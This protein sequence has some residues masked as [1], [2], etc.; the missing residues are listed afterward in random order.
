MRDTGNPPP[1]PDGTPPRA[2]SPGR[3]GTGRRARH[4]APAGRRGAAPRRVA[5]RRRW[6]DRVLV[7]DPGLIQLQAGWRSLVAMVTSLAAG[8]VASLALG[9]PVLLG[10]MVGGMMGLMSAFAVAEN[11]WERVARAV[12]WMP[13][14]FGAML[15]LAARFD[16]RTVQIVL[17]VCAMTLIFLLS[18]YGPLALLT[19]MML[20]NGVM[21]GMLAGIPAA[22]TGRAF[23]VALLA[24]AAVLATRL[25]LCFP[26]PREDLLRTQRAFVVE[27]R[28]LAGTAAAALGPDAGRRGVERRL[29]RSLR[30]LNL[31]TVTIDGRLAQP[32]TSADP[33]TAELL[34]R[35]LFDA[36]LALRG[37][38][39]SAL[40]LSRLDP[41]EPLREAVTAALEQVR[42]APLTRAG[43]LRRRVRA[44]R[45][46]VEE[47]C[48]E[49]R[50][51][52]A[53]GPAGTRAVAL[54]ARTADLLDVL[55]GSLSSWLALGRDLPAAPDAVPFQQAVALENNR[56]TGSAGPVRRVLDARSERGWRRIVPVVRAPLHAAAASAVVCPIALAVDSQR[57]YWGLVGVMITL[58]GTN[59]TSERLRKLAH[60]VVGTVVGAVVGVAVLE[61]IGRDHPYATI[62]VVVLGLSLGAYGM[63]R[64]YAL[65]VVGLVTALVQVYALT[66]PDGGMEALLGE[67]LL[68][69]ALGVA[70]ATACAALIFPLSTRAIVRE[71][72]HGYVAAVEHLVG[73]VALRWGEPGG[74]VRLR[75]AARAVEAALYQ[76][77]AV[78][79]PL[80]R[81][82]AGVRGRRADHRT[83]LLSTATGHARTLAAAADTVVRLPPPLAER[84]LLITGTLVGSLRTLDHRLTTGQAQGGWRRT[85]PL[86]Q[87]LRKALGSSPPRPEAA[88]LLTALG[89]LEALD[90]TL[91]AFAEARGLDVPDRPAGAPVA[92]VPPAQQHPGVGRAAGPV[93]SGSPSAGVRPE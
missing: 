91:A 33:V 52:A 11:T 76:V 26:T 69:N 14:P 80:V 8:H 58:F 93:R 77:T 48:E 72:E 90:E 66:T 78:S 51:D 9:L 60:R 54:A 49:A 75:G 88:R 35:H 6:W 16:D 53:A 83:A 17:T 23:A 70:V 63:Q 79:E 32:G 74:A 37:I 47:A 29:D 82:P 85:G 27:A 67:R 45:D 4:A 15:W 92:P 55:A 2:P 12:L 24:S 62:A 3:S 71:A 57:L 31:V 36:E 56:I 34:H 5:A 65:W 38:G 61:V 59:T 19:G 86:V 43:G 20:F 41:P 64:A 42:D 30:H 73:Q 68:D 87:E 22:L 28:R 39:R 84:A 13:F 40:E 89:E 50:R 18:R 1:R 7:A 25:L 44:I 10:L 21:L 46:R 81:M